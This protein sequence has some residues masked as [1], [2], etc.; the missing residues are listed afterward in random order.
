VKPVESNIEYYGGSD[1]EPAGRLL[2]V[3]L[4]SILN[5]SIVELVAARTVVASII[6][7]GILIQ[8]IYQLRNR[9]CEYGKQDLHLTH[10][11]SLSLEP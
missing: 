8:W 3:L 9:Q 2:E 6:D 11:I 4:A 1:K 7:K 10:D 5:G